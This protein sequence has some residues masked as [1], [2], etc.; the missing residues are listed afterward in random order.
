[1]RRIRTLF[2]LILLLQLPFLYSL[3]QSKAVSNYVQSLPRE[4]MPVP[5]QDWRGAIHLHTA[6]GGHSLGTYPELFE[7]A[8]EAGCRYLVMT[9]HSSLED[10]P[11]RGM[12]D[13]D[14]VVVH[15]TESDGYLELGPG[16]PLIAAELPERLGEEF[17]GMEIYNM[18]ENGERRNSF[19]QWI[20]FL[21]HR[22][23]YRDLFFFH[24]WE[25]TPERIEAWDRT[26]QTRRV[27]GVAG[28]DA[29]QNVGL[30]LQTAS[31][32]T[33]FSLLV[34]PYLHSLRFVNNHLTAPQGLEPSEANVVRL[35][36]EGALYVAFGRIADPTGFTFHAEMGGRNFPMGSTAPVG[37]RLVLQSPI[38]VKF[39]LLRDGVTIRELEGR[40]FLATAE[41]PGV[42]RLEAHLLEPPRLL[43]GK[44]WILSNPIF[45]R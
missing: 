44:P 39:R 8:K 43:R 2:L 18:H 45:V 4:E 40:R 10:S 19:F 32:Q 27:V 1:M 29:H 21:Y 35:I 13:P 38:P 33:V 31:G 41:A 3:C 6:R 42:Y 30:I 36:E 7:A 11:Y 16:G 15:G 5:F 23:A 25:L 24:L 17:A 22:I 34:D 14:L 37:S 20:N 26:L 12:D 28:N 9:E